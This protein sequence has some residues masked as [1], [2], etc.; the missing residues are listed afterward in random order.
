MADFGLSKGITDWRSHVTT[1]VMGSV[2]YIDPMYF[3]SGERGRER[4]DERGTEGKRRLKTWT[5]CTSSERGR[6]GKGTLKHGPN[7][8]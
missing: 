6:R 7:V 5:P 2:G 1:R 3:E 8:L 4:V